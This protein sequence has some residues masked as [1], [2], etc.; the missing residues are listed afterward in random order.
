MG[1]DHIDAPWTAEQV[2][3]LNR[4]QELSYFHPFTHSC[5]TVLVATADGWVCTDIGCKVYDDEAAT[6]P[7]VVQTW[8]HDSMAADPPPRPFAI[9]THEEPRHE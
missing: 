8:A 7:A 4:W 2:A 6:F 3:A 9:L 5:G 1:E